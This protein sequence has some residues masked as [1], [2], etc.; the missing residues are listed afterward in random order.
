M[1]EVLHILVSK[2]SFSKGYLPRLLHMLP[3]PSRL[4]RLVFYI[5]FAV[6]K[7][8]LNVGDL[9]SELERFRS[10]TEVVCHSSVYLPKGAP[11][12]SQKHIVELIEAKLQK[13]ARRSPPVLR[14]YLTL[15]EGPGKL[16]RRFHNIRAKYLRLADG[17]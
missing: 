9:D 7:L 8:E 15:D 11:L 3:T 17:C 16:R 14:I 12:T 5:P 1:L 13:L 2:E 10:L 4:R 6:D